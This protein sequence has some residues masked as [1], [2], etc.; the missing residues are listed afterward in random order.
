[1]HHLFIINRFIIKAAQSGLDNTGQV[2]AA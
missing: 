2:E 1:L